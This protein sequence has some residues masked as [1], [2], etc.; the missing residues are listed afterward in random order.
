MNRPRARQ[1]AWPAVSAFW[2]V[3]FLVTAVASAAEEEKPFDPGNLGQAVIAIAIFL[4]LLL[5]LKKFAWGPIIAQLH[6]REDRIGQSVTLAQK[7]QTQAADLLA[8]Y[9]AQLADAQTRVEQLLADAREQAETH[10]Q[11]L[12]AQARAEADRAVKQAKREIELARADALQ[13]L[14]ETTARMAI[15]LTQRILQREVTPDDHQRML[16]EALEDI[17]LCQ[18]EDA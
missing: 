4:V 3:T 2:L 12:V 6:S 9:E 11:E 1:H 18:A 16:K 14:R 10:R 7:Q 17:E 5:V 13:N 8:K 15:E